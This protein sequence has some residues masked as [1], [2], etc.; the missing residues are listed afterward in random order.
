M[1]NLAYGFTMNGQ[2]LRREAPSSERIG[3]KL[4]RTVN[5]SIHRC[6]E[7]H[8]DNPWDRTI[9]GSGAGFIRRR[10]SVPASKVNQL[11]TES[12]DEVVR[13]LERQGINAIG[14]NLPFLRCG[15]S[16]FLQSRVSGFLKGVSYLLKA[17]TNVLDFMRIQG[18]KIFCRCSGTAAA[19]AMC[20]G[21]LRQSFVW[22]TSNSIMAASLVVLCT[23]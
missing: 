14:L 23:Q 3:A 10:V 1:I 21:S 16:P 7:F 22:H 19:A 17:D 4:E 11:E 20:S 18:A 6:T 9:C 12:L 15:C 8:C 2:E 5:H 13:T